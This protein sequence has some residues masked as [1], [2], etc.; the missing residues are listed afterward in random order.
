M[1]CLSD[2]VMGF[3]KTMLG[4]INGETRIWS[5]AIALGVVQVS[6]PTKRNVVVYR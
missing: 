2:D 6:P 4:Q 3:C 5:E 1:K